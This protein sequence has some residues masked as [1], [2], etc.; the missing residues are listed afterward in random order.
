MLLTRSAIAALIL[1]AGSGLA[2]AQTAATPAPTA[3]AATAVAPAAAA[4]V[5]AQPEANQN[6]PAWQ[7][8]RAACA[9]DVAKHCGD[10]ERVKGERGK[11]RAC[12]DTHK[13]S[14]STECSA[15]LAEREAAAKAKKS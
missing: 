1:V 3:P 4:P 2:M 13:A 5:A 8:F 7:K 15:A 14:L 10:V 6:N 11:V 12:L 9:A